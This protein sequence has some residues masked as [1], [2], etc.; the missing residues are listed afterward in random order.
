M[1]SLTIRMCRQQQSIVHVMQRGYLYVSTT[2]LKPA[3]LPFMA[4][5]LHVLSRHVSGT[6][7]HRS[8]LSELA[9]DGYYFQQ[10]H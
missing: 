1:L 8:T 3:P 5:S 10:R 4:R 7:T 2:W 6:I 9:P